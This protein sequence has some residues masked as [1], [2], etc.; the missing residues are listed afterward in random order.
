ML[1][2]LTLT[3][4]KREGVQRTDSLFSPHPGQPAQNLNKP[5]NPEVQEKAVR[6]KFT[7]EQKLRI[8]KEADSLAPGQLGALLRREGLYYSN[9][10]TWRRQLKEGTLEALSPQRRGPKTRQ[11][12]PL[13]KQVAQ[14]TKE[15]QKL[16]KKL[17]QAELIIDFQK[18]I[19]EILQ[20]P[21]ETQEEQQD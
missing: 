13:A 1:S 3:G 16:Q 9:L 6:R 19:S 15:N 11:P 10:R 20:I 2:S 14:L 8:I 21:I 7:A 5:P 4:E 18:K 17:R 12:N